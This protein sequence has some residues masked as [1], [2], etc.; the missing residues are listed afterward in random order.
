MRKFMPQFAGWL[1]VFLLASFGFA[2]ADAAFDLAGPKIEV[3]VQRDGKELPIGQVPSLQPGDRLWIHPDLPENQS[4]HYLMVVGFLRGATNPPPEKLFTKFETW[5]KSVREE[6]VM[7]KVPP[8]AQQALIFLAPETGGDFS[9]LRSTVRGKPGAFVRAAQDLQQASL[10]R[11]RLEMYLAE[12]RK[13]SEE[14]ASDLQART[15]LLARS[16]SIKVDQACFEKP[17]AQQLQ[18]LTQNS[19]QLV[20]EDA[21]TQSMV[22]M[23]TSG[24]SID[25]LTQISNAPHIGGAAYSPYVGA[26]VDV[27]RILGSAHTAKYQ[28]IPALAIPHGDS[29]NLKLNNPPSF[30]DPK[31]VIV[32]GLPAIEKVQPP[33]LRAVDPKQIQCAEHPTLVLPADGAPLI[34]GTGLGHDFTLD[35]ADTGGKQIKLPAKADATLGGFV[36]DTHQLHHVTLPPSLTA[37]LNGLWGFDSFQGPSYHLRSS[38]PA[39]WEVSP[40]DASALIVGRQ[41]TIHLHSPEAVCVEGVAAQ[42]QGKDLRTDWK[43]TQPDTLEVKVTLQDAAPG[44]LRFHVKK[45]GAKRPDIVSLQSYSQAAQLDS[46]EMHAGDSSGTLSGTR[47]DQVASLELNGIRFTPGDLTRR[48]QQDEMKMSAGSAAA[49]QTLVSAPQS[50]AKVT[51]KDGRSLDVKAS[52]EA[53]RPQVVLLAKTSASASPTAG[54]DNIQL[55]GTGQMAQD[56]TLRFS[57][58]SLVPQKFAPREK[59]EVATSDE[60]FHTE[61]STAKGSLTLQDPQTVLA[62]LNPLQDLGPSAFGQLKFRA[63]DAD[64]SAGDWQPLVTLVRVPTLSEVRCADTPDQQCKLIGQ[65]LFLIDSVS[66]NSQFSDAVQVPEGFFENALTIPPPSGKVLYLKLRDDPSVVNTATVPV[67]T[68]P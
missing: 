22:A 24:T 11:A 12:L 9:T 33:P 61:L 45:Y 39:T 32:I 26:V 10:D 63:V 49:V 21:H 31:S 60:S 44:P 55:S 20:L 46:F 62:V 57:L 34:F 14:N 36:I 35:L 19:D 16:L 67:V 27:V 29:L 8:E 6:G 48:N 41:D 5:S 23:L 4:A 28:Y 17:A 47:L 58:K 3:R 15:N 53:P 56:Q 52:I 40:S 7:V 65:G 51:L 18:C 1:A 68:R 13:A 59:V 2:Y 66:T 64:G 30:H 37:T 50:T 42:D 54:D 38:Q 43:L 25:L